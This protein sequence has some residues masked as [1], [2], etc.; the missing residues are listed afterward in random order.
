M[1]KD[2]L[3][4][5]E[6]NRDLGIRRESVARHQAPYNAT[7]GTHM[8]QPKVAEHILPDYGRGILQ[9]ELLLVLPLRCV[10]F[11]DRLVWPLLF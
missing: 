2:Q 8:F 10:T 3:L 4:P 11:T 1:S 7:V 9:L 5:Q 6:G